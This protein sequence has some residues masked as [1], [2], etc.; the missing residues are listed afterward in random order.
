MPDQMQKYLMTMD[1]INCEQIKNI[2][3]N[4]PE[5]DISHALKMMR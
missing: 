4:W 2:H 3:L 1:Q 5:T